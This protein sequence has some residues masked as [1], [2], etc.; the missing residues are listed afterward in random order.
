MSKIGIFDSG[1]GGLTVLRSIVQRMPQY[2]YIYLGDSARA[3]YG[4]KTQKEIY[5]Y[6]KEAVSYLF[7]CDC[8]LIILA[9]N[10]AS[11]EALRKIQQEY[12]PQ[13][14]PDRRVLGVIIPTAEK[15]AEGGRFKKIGILATEGTVNSGAYSREIH[16]LIPEAE[17]M[18]KAA[19]KLVPLIESGLGNTHEIEKEISECTAPLLEQHIEA[20]IL[21][22]THYEILAKEFHRLLPRGV[23]IFQQSPIVAEKLKDYLDRH[24]DIRESLSLGGGVHYLCTGD[25]GYFLKEA[26]NLFGYKIEDVETVKIAGGS[27]KI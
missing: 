27:D 13:N 7:D 24:R 23:Q 11:A 2:E 17:V 12:L 15:I 6:T 19:P 5:Q 21:G 9:C 10:T 22:C 14:F 25:S 18:Q 26:R 20:L 16:K 4:P 3:P 1:F 8:R